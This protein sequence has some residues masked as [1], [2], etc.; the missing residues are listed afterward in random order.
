M[1]GLVLFSSLKL[2]L[3]PM[4]PYLQSNT[5]LSGPALA[6]YIFRII[7]ALCA[8]IIHDP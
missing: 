5:T 6:L 8:A 3:V 7:E 1:E 2:E 4:L